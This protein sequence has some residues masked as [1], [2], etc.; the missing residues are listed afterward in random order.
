[1]L[2]NINDIAKQTLKILNERKLKPTPENYNEIFEEISKKS[3]IIS[4]NQLKIEKYKSLLVQNYQQELKSKHIRTIEELI[5][6]LIAILNRQSGKQFSE[7]YELMSLIMNVL[8][9]SKDKKARDLAKVSLGR[10]SK[11]MDSESIFL[12][13]KKWKELES[14]YADNDLEIELSKI[15]INKYEDYE[16]IIKKLLAR[17]QERSLEY[18]ATLLSSSLMPSLVEDL[19]ILGFSQNLAQKPFVMMDTNFKKEL[20]ANVNRRIAVDNMY[21]QKNLNF[22]NEN[23]QKTQELLSL[24]EHSNKENI[25]F[26]NNLTPDEKGEVRLSFDDLKEKLTQ[27]SQRI[28]SLNI[29]IKLTQSNEAREDWSMDKELDKLDD[30]FEKYKVNY[31]L[32][33]FSI[34]NYRFIMEKYGL[35][36][37]N[38]IFVRFKKTLKE[39]CEDVDELW[40]VDEKSYLIITP[41][42][43]KEE[44]ENLVNI[45]VQNLENFRFIYKQDVIMPKIKVFYLDKQSKPDSNIIE[46]ILA[47]I[48]I[49]DREYEAQYE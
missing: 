28:D 16:S 18:F 29:Q 49:Q 34:V 2:P 31:S 35:E 40:M 21:V 6:F 3:G 36:S 19:K 25:D 38:E 9:K 23:L 30:N 45:N 47:Q 8:Q 41:G 33:V 13:S 48:A 44:I 11:T 39:S 1:M 46:E 15:G 22:F 12:L 43:N 7:F 14:S 37:L 42:K 5:S 10:L 4:Q 20:L 24:L 17:L 26:M 27:L 32:A